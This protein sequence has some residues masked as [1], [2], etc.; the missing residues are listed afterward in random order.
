MRWRRGGAARR[1]AASGG[2]DGV[3]LLGGDEIVDDE[4]VRGGVELPEAGV[5]AVDGDVGVECIGSIHTRGGRD[6]RAEAA[7]GVGRDG[8]REG[9]TRGFPSRDASA[10]PD[11][12]S[13]RYP[14]RRSMRDARGHGCDGGHVPRRGS[15]SE[16]SRATP[17]AFGTGASGLMSAN[18]LQTIKD[19]KKIVGVPL[20]SDSETSVFSRIHSPL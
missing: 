6:A 5:E 14:V 9:S 10:P 17:V 11:G 18:R 15:G 8:R 20:A 19:G 12:S 3:A 1:A 7:V 4:D 16:E 13:A 2:D